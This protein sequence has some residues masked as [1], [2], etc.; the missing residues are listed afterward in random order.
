[1]VKYN[2]DEELDLIFHALSDTTRRQIL[3]TIAKKS[4]TVSELAEPY[5]MSLAA[6]SKHL[7]VL[8]KAGFVSRT[9]EGRI[10]RCQLNPKPILTA[11]KQLAS[12]SDMWSKKLD[13]L[14]DYFKKIKD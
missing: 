4:C 3:E 9:K 12:L 8:E 11:E 5:A 14:D 1:M 6:I 10:H 13:A 2:G 7:K